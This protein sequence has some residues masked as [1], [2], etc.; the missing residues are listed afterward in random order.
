[1]VPISLSLNRQAPPIKQLMRSIRQ[2]ISFYVF[3]TPFFIPFFI[4]WVWPLLNSF[5]LSF[6]KWSGFGEPTF[7]GV[8]NY[9]KLINDTTFHQALGNTLLFTV[10]AVPLQIGLGLILARLLNLKFV[11]FRSLFRT[12]YLTP[13]ILSPVI[14]GTIF[15]F[16]LDSK[17]GVINYLLIG[18]GIQAVPWLISPFWMRVSIIMVSVWRYTGWSA[19]IYLAG[20]QNISP[21]FEESARI[22]GA[23]ELQIFLKIIIPL[24]A[25]LLLFTT[26]MGTISGLQMFAEPFAL[27]ANQKGPDNSAYT[28]VYALWRNAFDFGQFGKASAMA[29]VLFALTFAATLIQLIYRQKRE[30]T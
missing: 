19:V 23:S 13:F 9:A 25:P 15:L 5:Y 27:S 12:L 6:T 3:V 14:I 22:D 18:L 1:M 17:F 29:F 16:L 2:N 10:V 11:R 8:D 20:M 30:A 21:E 24:L 26:V 7:I 4:F 28:L